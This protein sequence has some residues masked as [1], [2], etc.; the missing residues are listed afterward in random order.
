MEKKKFNIINLIVITFGLFSVFL[1][2]YLVYQESSRAKV[3]C[4]SFNETYVLNIFALAHTCNGEVIKE[5]SYGWD[6][7]S[8]IKSY[9]KVNLSL[10]DRIS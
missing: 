10:L 3:F 5:Y 4:D 2:V 7:E 6:F 9:S 8:N 1:A